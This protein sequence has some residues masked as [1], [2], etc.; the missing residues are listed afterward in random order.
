[1]ASSLITR[2]CGNLLAIKVPLPYDSRANYPKDASKNIK[3]CLRLL[4]KW[5][6]EKQYA[7][8]RCPFKTVSFDF[9]SQKKVLLHLRMK[10]SNREA[11]LNRIQ[12]KTCQILNKKV[13]K[14]KFGQENEN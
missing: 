11:I 4:N 12:V 5:D 13:E 8:S 7:M 2:R 14:L 10:Y 6:Y 9:H 1:M 3:K